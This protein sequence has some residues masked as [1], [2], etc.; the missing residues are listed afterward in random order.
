MIKGTSDSAER[1]EYRKSM[2]SI[3]IAAPI[4]GGWWKQDRHHCTLLHATTAEVKEVRN[5]FSVKL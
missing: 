1:S 4:A 5:T 2:Y 3:A